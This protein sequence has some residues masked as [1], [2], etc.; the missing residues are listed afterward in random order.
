MVELGRVKFLGKYD[1]NGNLVASGSAYSNEICLMD[2]MCYTVEM[3]DSYGDGW[4]GN[5][6]N[7]G[8]T[9]MS[10]MQVTVE[11]TLVIVL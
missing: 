4:N 9:E 11:M 7:I 5:M 6:L 10:L 1:E 2:D 8:G 3:Q